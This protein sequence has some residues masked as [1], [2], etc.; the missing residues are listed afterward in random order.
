MHLEAKKIL[1]SMP[2]LPDLLATKLE[3]VRISSLN[4]TKAG[5]IYGR[6][7]PSKVVRVVVDKLGRT[8]EQRPMTRRER[9]RVRDG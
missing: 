3:P 7:I 9:R 4:P 5:R 2:D 8:I 1:Q 6:F